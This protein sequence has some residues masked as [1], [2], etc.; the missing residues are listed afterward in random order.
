MLGTALQNQETLVQFVIELDLC[1]FQSKLL[2][3][4]LFTEVIFLS[5]PLDEVVFLCLLDK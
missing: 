4:L 5:I 2:V 3:Q 1:S